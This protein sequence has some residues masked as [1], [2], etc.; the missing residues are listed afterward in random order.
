[1]FRGV[2]LIG[3]G[4]NEKE[5][6][7]MEVPRFEKLT[8]G[9]LLKREAGVFGRRG[10]AIFY[11]PTQKREPAPSH[12][13]SEEYTEETLF[14][15]LSRIGGKHKYPN[16]DPKTAADLFHRTLRVAGIESEEPEEIPLRMGLEG[17]SG[18]IVRFPVEHLK[19]GRSIFEFLSTLYYDHRH[20]L[21]S[22]IQIE[23]AKERSAG[24][25]ALVTIRPAVTVSHIERYKPV[26]IG[27]T[28]SIDSTTVD[29]SSVILEFHNLDKK[30]LED[31]RKDRSS[32][33]LEFH[34]LDKKRLEDLRKTMDSED[35]LSYILFDGLLA[36]QV[37][38]IHSVM[39]DSKDLPRGYRANFISRGLGGLPTGN[40]GELVAYSLFPA[41][42]E[43]RLIDSLH[44]LQTISTGPPE[45][46][47]DYIAVNSR[48]REVVKNEFY[49]DMSF[50]E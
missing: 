26:Y 16:V 7:T 41:E 32:V 6:E 24:Q 29:R 35:S 20:I 27:G 15:K 25:V 8:V 34:N 33:I 5:R 45:L 40:L 47:Q 36:Q 4:K 21:T 49:Q 28:E 42:M 43:T 18:Y 48:I 37:A 22:F 30:R 19:R 2:R 44:L 50:R 31:L 12:M 23:K 38:Y 13:A 39:W 3:L 14:G 1:L 17:T 10:L 46:L 11:D 9:I